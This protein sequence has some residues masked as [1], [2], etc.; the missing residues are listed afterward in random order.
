MLFI[1]FLVMPFVRQILLEKRKNLLEHKRK[2]I[3][4]ENVKRLR[5]LKLSV[6]NRRLLDILQNP[7]EYYKVNFERE[8]H[9]RKFKVKQ[10]VYKV[11]VKTLLERPNWNCF[12]SS[13]LRV[14]VAIR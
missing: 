10:N 8:R 1:F 12:T 3:H 9:S 7:K 6:D 14:A 4:G 5:R 11:N 2:R 13:I